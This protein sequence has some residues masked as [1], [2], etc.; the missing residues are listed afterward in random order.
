[1][2]RPK[3]Q[4]NAPAYRAPRLTGTGIR[5]L[6]QYVAAPVLLALLA[7]DVALY[8][9]FRFGFQSCYGVLCLL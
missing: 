9:V 6:V 4:D 5:V 2:I 7:L 3:T 8:L 1:M